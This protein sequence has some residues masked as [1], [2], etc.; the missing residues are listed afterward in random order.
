MTKSFYKPLKEEIVSES[1]DSNKYVRDA[2]TSLF[3]RK[4]WKPT[5]EAFDKKLQTLIESG[6]DNK[7]A[8]I[9][10]LD[11]LTE[12]LK[13][14]EPEVMNLIKKSGKDIKQSRV[15]VA[16]N[17][18]QALIAHALLKNIEF[19]N[20]PRLQIILKPKDHPLIEKYGVIKIGN[21]K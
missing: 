16:G 11:H 6:F 10:I 12:V 18:F 13:N 21:E 5:F 15:A 17:N 4:Y 20:I 2:L 19:G 3:S 7:K 1:K 9:E 8:L 14:S